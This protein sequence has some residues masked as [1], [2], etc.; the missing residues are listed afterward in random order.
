MAT[1]EQI[2]KID[3]IVIRHLPARRTMTTSYNPE[4]RPQDV[5]FLNRRSKEYAENDF[6]HEFFTDKYNRSFVSM[7]WV[8][9]ICGKWIVSETSGHGETIRQSLK[10]DAG[11]GDTIEEAYAAYIKTINKIKE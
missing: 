6:K 7:S 4:A 11:V 8:T 2:L 1:L 3:G 10:Y 5:D 9:P